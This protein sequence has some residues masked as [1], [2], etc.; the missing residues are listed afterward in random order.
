MATTLSAHAQNGK[1]VTTKKTFSR[2]TSVSI[3]IKADRAILWALLTNA[4]DFPRWNSTVVSIEGNI[5]QGEKIKLKSTLD[6][7]RSFKLRVTAFEPEKRLAWGDG[8]GTRVYTL[9]DNGKGGVAFSMREKIGGL[10]FPMYA[11]YIPPFDAA[12]EQ[13]AADLKKEAELIQSAKN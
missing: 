12:F 7:K 1:A 3:D 9:E 2:E 13:F 11:K 4:S 6:P 5:Q 10:M 8:K